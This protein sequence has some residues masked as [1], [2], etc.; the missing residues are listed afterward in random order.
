MR[1][2]KVAWKALVAYYNELFF[3]VG[4][5]VIWWITGGFFVGLLVLLGYPLFVANGPWWIAP[6]I[7]IPAGPAIAAMAVVARRVAREVHVDRSYYFAGFRMFWR[8]ALALSAIGMGVLALLLLNLMFYI[9]QASGLLQALAF[10][11]LY[12]IIFWLGMGMYVF[13]ILVGMENP[14]VLGALKTSAL[15]AFANPLFTLLLMVIAIALT[16]LSVVLAIL[17]ILAWPAVMVLLGEQSIRLFLERAGVK[18]EESGSIG[19]NS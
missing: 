11:W 5:S 2:F 7:A 4:M 10:L 15:A 12:L 16:A 19:D 6:I 13:P 3:M 18:P 8:K 9:T 1:A 17:I 14:T